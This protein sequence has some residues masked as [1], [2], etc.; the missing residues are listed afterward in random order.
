MELHRIYIKTAKGLEEIQSRAYKLPTHLRRLL[1]MVDGRSTA[2][3]LISRL[4][5]LGNIEL[6]LAELAAGGFIAP[7]GSGSSAPGAASPPAPPEFNL[8]EAKYSIRSIL[9]GTMG[10]AAE[11]RIECVEAV[12]TPDQLQVELNTLHELLPKLLSRQQAEPVWRQL[13]PI[14]RALEQRASS[15]SH[16][17][18]PQTKPAAASGLPAHLEFNLAKAKDVIRFTLLGALGPS[19]AHRI[20]RVEAT[21]T[22]EELRVELDA[23][24][25]MLPKVL[26]RRQAE[27]AWRQLE[28]IMISITEPSV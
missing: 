21:A 4:T 12:T 20:E 3:E 27:Q 9:L 5:S 22:P 23:I 26:S 2:T 17:A 18:A 16:G 19:A 28:P 8:D 6:E 10:P 14:A 13:E 25:D 11:Y 15:Q 24:R 1:I 7:P